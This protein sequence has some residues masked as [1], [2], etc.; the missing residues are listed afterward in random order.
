MVFCKIC[1]VPM[2]SVMSFSKDKHEKFT[3]C[4]KCY[5]ETKHNSLRNDELNFREIL[6]EK[7]YRGEIR[8]RVLERM[9]VSERTI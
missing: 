9:A 7:I 5:G 3:R 4:P 8:G 2:I 1:N 6:D